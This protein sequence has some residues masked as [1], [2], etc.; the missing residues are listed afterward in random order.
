M[1]EIKTEET[2]L[3]YA[4]GPK[5][6]LPYLLQLRNWIF[7]PTTPQM[8]VKIGF[9]LL[10]SIGFVFLIWN[11]LSLFALQMRFLIRENKNIS[12]QEYLQDRAVELNI[13]PDYIVSKLLTFFS[14]SIL[15][16]AL[17]LFG[18]VLLWRQKK[19]FFWLSLSAELF[20]L[21][22]AIFFVG[23]DFFWRGVT[24]L[25]KWMLFAVLVVLI[26]YQFYFQAFSRKNS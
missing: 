25:D 24:V 4:T 3:E 21:G 1:D 11:I 23:G 5:S 13:N 15:C 7:G 16:W 9:Y 8:S 20:Y 18:M 10:F 14:I 2:E 19:L 26:F 17:F 6:P 12:I 22:M